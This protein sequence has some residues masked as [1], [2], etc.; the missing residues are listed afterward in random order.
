[1]KS[2]YTVTVKVADRMMVV[3]LLDAIGPYAQSAE[4]MIDNGP[5]Q[6]AAVSKPAPRAAVMTRR[7]PKRSK[8]NEAIRNRLGRGQ[9]SITDL[10]DAL[11]SA[12]MSPASLSTGIAAL[13]KTGEISRV[14]D[15][16]YELKAA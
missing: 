1:M 10:K 4:I 15:G 12:G 16:V 2:Q 5:P 14:G 7:G 13:T 11:E 8:V 9:A 6:P 3:D